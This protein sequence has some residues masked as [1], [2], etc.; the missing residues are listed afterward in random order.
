MGVPLQD[1]LRTLVDL[2][3][4]ADILLFATCMH[5]AIGMLQSRVARLKQAGARVKYV[6]DHNDDDTNLNSS[7]RLAGCEHLQHF[8]PQM[9]R[10]PV[11]NVR[12][13]GC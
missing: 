4:A 12:S 10:L 1:G 7:G 3:F 13:T 2:R 9:V 5:N 8:L 6:Q 11:D